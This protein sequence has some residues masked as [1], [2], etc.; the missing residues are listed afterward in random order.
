MESDALFLES[1]IGGE[2][3]AISLLVKNYFGGE[4][5]VA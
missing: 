2:E 5:R 3:I 1:N 4:S